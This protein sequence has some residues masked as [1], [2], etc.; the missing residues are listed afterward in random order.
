MASAQQLFKDRDDERATFLEALDQVRRSAV[1]PE[2]VTNTSFPRGHVLV[3]WGIGGI[4]KTRL[5]QELERAIREGRY[6]DAPDE[7]RRVT[8]RWN[9]EDAGKLD[10]LHLVLQ[11]RAALIDVER[12]WAAFDL[13][14]AVYWER[15]HQSGTSLP[16]V[17]GD[18]SRFGTGLVSDVLDGIVSA[19]G[20]V[21]PTALA[22]DALQ[23]I[24]RKVQNTRNLRDLRRDCPVFAAIV[25][26]DGSPGEQLIHLPSLLAWQLQRIQR[27]R[28]VDLVIFVDTF[29]ELQR[30]T[31]DSGG[32]E[33]AFRCLAWWVPNALFVVTGRERLRWADGPDRP[34]DYHGP[35]CWPSLGSTYGAAATRQHR[36]GR[37]PE[38]DVTEF[39]EEAVVEEGVSSIPLEIRGRIAEA[40]RGWPLYLDV[41]VS[42]FL[43][44]R[45]VL[46]NDPRP[47]EFGGKLPELV[48]RLMRDLDAQE[49]DLMRAAALLPH[50]TRTSLTL[51]VGDGAGTAEALTRFCRRPFVG[52]E[53]QA[54]MDRRDDPAM[55][56]HE[57]L[58]ESLRSY[59]G[60]ELSPWGPREWQRAAARL[61]TRLPELLPSPPARSPLAHRDILAAAFVDGFKL[62]SSGAH[63]PDWLVD[64]SLRLHA[65]GA[66]EVL[67][68]VGEGTERAARAFSSGVRGIAERRIGQL[69]TAETL[70]T[71]ALSAPSLSERAKAVFELYLANV[72]KNRGRYPE[73]LLRYEALEQR[74]ESAVR[75]EAKR[76]RLHLQ[77]RQG[78]LRAVLGSLE[79]DERPTEIAAEL[80]LIEADTLA[81]T[82]HLA[83]ADAA[84][85]QAFALADGQ[86]PLRQ[87]IT[88][89]RLRNLAWW[90]PHAAATAVE[91][92]DPEDGSESDQR[93]DFNLMA[94]RIVAEAESL[95]S[96]QLWERVEWARGWSARRGFPAGL[97]W[98]LRSASFAAVLRGE[99]KRAYDCLREYE[100]VCDQ[101]GVDKP[102]AAIA[103]IWTGEQLTDA[104]GDA[105][106]DWPDGWPAVRKR[107]ATVLAPRLAT[108]R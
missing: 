65:Q 34:R 24:G 55:S 25:E 22:T 105:Y 86:P 96:E 13:A 8:L 79:H 26:D 90:R 58:R 44:R 81:I 45:A 16:E 21:G 78:S 46:G 9:F 92:L 104:D 18:S 29:E 66:Y 74:G 69:A 20:L 83:R 7:N 57:A 12:R 48:L 19:L 68:S 75:L 61:A 89:N 43:Q 107:W 52:L 32:V 71:D 53:P 54:W 70:L 1:G 84:Y 23:N 11:L 41:S 63:I 42:L 14:L 103:T 35:A 2:D 98:V 56:L 38:R 64:A 88:V 36:V 28:R 27:S 106:A 82:G 72:L 33:R 99:T 47:E 91:S 102:W 87:L 49:R 97:G 37:L 59:E 108:G 51:V 15:V 5:S 17:L 77:Q 80:A 94:A 60:V 85:A 73:A 50:F 10:V 4:G 101:L 6:R 40:A 62:C 3:Y 67:A 95:P 100:R 76:W 93:S 39:L 31:V 30:Q